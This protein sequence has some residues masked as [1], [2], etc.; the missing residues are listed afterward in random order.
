MA[1]R[2]KD[3]VLFDG[4]S[5]LCS[6]CLSKVPAKILLRDNKVFL[7]K[8]CDDHGVYE[9]LLEEDAGFFLRHSKYDKPC[10][11]SIPETET[12]YGCPYDCGLCPDHEQHTCIALLEITQR[13]DLG[14][15]ICYADS[16]H[17]DELTLSQMESMIDTYQK[18]E[19]GEAEIL[20]ISGG[21]PT[22]HPQVLEAIRL[23]RSKCLRYVMLNTNGL[24]IAD[25][26]EFAAALGEFSNRFEVYLQFDGLDDRIYQ[27]LRGR[28]L[29][30]TKLRALDNLAA[31]N[32]P[33]TLVMTVHRGVNDQEIGRV[34]EFGIKAPN[35]RGINFQPLAFSGRVEG[36]NPANRI[37]L[38]GVLKE[39]EAQTNGMLRMDDFVPLPCDVERVAITMLYRKDETFI[40]LT[41]KMD[42]SKYLPL[43]DNTLSFYAEDLIKNAGEAM[44]C[45]SKCECFNFAKDFFKLAPLGMKGIMARSKKDFTT[46]NLFRITVT[47][48][49][50]RYNF[51]MKAMKKEC[52]HILTPDGRRIPFSAFNLIHRKS[53]KN[54]GTVV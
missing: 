13:C 51:E 28:D 3:Y 22:T 19:S 24:R 9:E 14:C 38:T 16:G 34:I 40:P 35:V 21:E 1:K 2:V 12:R 18:A 47:S 53:A 36:A 44:C 41:R 29:L 43:I 5:S 8:T 17:G 42:I 39:V 54:V 23:A 7:Q 48:F 32:V 4:T 27:K 37:T 20:Q 49:L 33:V 6:M 45:G 50:D 46:A 31:H 10:T 26:P 15:P 30:Q 11:P 25:E 52:V